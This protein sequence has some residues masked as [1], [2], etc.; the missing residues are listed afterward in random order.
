MLRIRILPPVWIARR[1]WS[2][3]PDRLTMSALNCTVKPIDGASSGAVLGS[4]STHERRRYDNEAGRG[5]R[6]FVSG[7]LDRDRAFA[8]ARAA[9]HRGD[10]AA[11]DSRRRA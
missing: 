6:R 1:N 5:G 3:R 7:V 11:V 9:L 4:R 8:G 10:V 2:D